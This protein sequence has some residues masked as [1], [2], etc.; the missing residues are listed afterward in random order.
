MHLIVITRVK[1]FHSPTCIYLKMTYSP[2]LH[3]SLGISW[4]DA[5]MD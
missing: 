4:Y 1:L 2:K 5:A 3:H